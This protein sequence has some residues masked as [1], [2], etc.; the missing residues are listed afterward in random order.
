MKQLKTSKP[1]IICVPNGKW[2]KNSEQKFPIRKVCLIRI[3][4]WMEN[5][6]YTW[7]T[8]LKVGECIPWYL[9][10]MRCA[11]WYHLYHLKN[12]KN[13]HGGGLILVN[14]WFK[15]TCH[16]LFQDMSV[17]IYINFFLSSGGYNFKISYLKNKRRHG[18][19]RVHILL[20]N[21]ALLP[22]QRKYYFWPRRSKCH[23]KTVKFYLE[24][25]EFKFFVRSNN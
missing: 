14:L 24:I 5:G 13:T 15:R 17:K 1:N 6:L 16:P 10:V 12:V 9:Y 11:I 21:L 23:E 22:L 2:T 4:S 19:R 7:V 20:N 8:V 25:F 18:M 3:F